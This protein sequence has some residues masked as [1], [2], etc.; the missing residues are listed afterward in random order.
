MIRQ[1]TIDDTNKFANLILNMYSN[2]DNLEWFSPMPFDYDNVKAMIENPRFF[3]I[4]YFEGDILCGV[5]SLDYKCG[6]LI[7]KIDLPPE[8]NTD[9]L[10]EIGFHMVNSEYRGNGIMKKMVKYLLDK[11]TD[12]GYEWSFGKVHKDNLASSKSLMKTGFEIYSPFAKT[13]KKKDFIFLS[14]QSFFSKKGKENAQI[15]L[16]KN[17]DNEDIIVEYNILI[18]RL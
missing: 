18:K 10:V 1:L 4:G 9:K 2:L 8:C 14:S 3:I 11:M 17:K 6:K 15:T 7:G 5:G 13:V 16:E 12:D